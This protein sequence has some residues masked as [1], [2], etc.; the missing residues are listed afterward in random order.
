MK[1]IKRH[2]VTLLML[3]LILFAVLGG[4]VFVSVSAYGSRW[5]STPY[6]T[7]L[8]RAKSEVTAGDIFD[9]N[10]TL[11]VTTASDGTRTYPISDAARISLS[12]VLGDPDGVIPT[13]AETMFAGELL[14]FQTPLGERLRQ[15]LAGQRRGSDVYLTIDAEI[16][17][18]A[19]RNFPEG[20]RG[21]VALYN[22]KTGEVLAL[23]S[24][25]TADLDDLAVAGEDQS[26]G[27]LL[28]RAIQGRYAPGS[29]FKVVTLC[30]ALQ[31]LTGV[32]SRT[33]ACEGTYPVTDEVALTDTEG[34]GH[35]E[36]T[37][38][39]A[40]TKSCNIAFGQLA[41]ELGQ[42]NL[43][44]TAEEM[45][46]NGSFLFPDLIVYESLFPQSI[47]DKGTLAWTGVG[48]GELMA[49]PM[50]MAML[51]GMAANAGAMVTPTMLLYT[52]EQGQTTLNEKLTKTVFS[53]PISGAVAATLK[54]YMI[55]TVETGTATRAAVDGYV[56]GGKTGTAQV[57][58]TGGKYAPHSWYIG[59]CA[60]E[61][62]PLAIAVIIENGGAGSQAAASLAG[63]VM[64]YA[65]GRVGS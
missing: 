47:A 45:G 24:A 60:D 21:A 4:Y 11:L 63:K 20:K 64:E 10:R 16:Q 3:V 38:E 28:N 46:F 41:L 44:R 42:E 53:R 25:P 8:S 7:R 19:Y 55:Q 15:M 18:F 26:A 37:L 49:S 1:H 32:T 36:L 56:I 27:A 35:G 52:G 34:S 13:G 29:I 54:E 61:S 14:G 22:Y 31:N 17:K 30:S 5:F 12:H 9:R 65:I 62:A 57:N 59:F 33:F 23:Y 40:F 58:S 51:A 43:R 39:E 2:V 6:N 48:Q 50:H